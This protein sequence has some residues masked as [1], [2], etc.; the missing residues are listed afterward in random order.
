MNV[1]KGVRR[2]L[3]HCK[4]IMVGA[5]V[6]PHVHPTAIIAEDAKVTSPNDLY[7]E[8]YASIPRG[9][10]IMNG[11]NG[12]FIMKRWSFS[13]V[14]LLVICGNHM[15]VVGTPCI[16]VTNEMKKQLDVSGKYSK[17]VIVEEDV[18]IGARVTLLQGAH[19]GRGCIIAAGAV[20]TNGVPAYSVWGGVPAKHI[21]WKWSIDEIIE[22]EKALYPENKRFSREELIKMRETVNQ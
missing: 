12:R 21:K 19:I 11:T 9:A 7:M 16:K 1:I 13:S 14:D 15:P 22:H 5:P 18:W 17:D 8:E 3:S 4:R 6:Y 10:S 2:L 20:V